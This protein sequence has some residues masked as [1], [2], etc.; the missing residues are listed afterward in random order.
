VELY[1]RHTQLNYRFTAAA[2]LLSAASYILIR[3][4]HAME[5]NNREEKIIKAKYQNEITLLT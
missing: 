3:R 4:N 5:V 1:A 2:L